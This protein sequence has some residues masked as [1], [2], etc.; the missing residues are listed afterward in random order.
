VTNAGSNDAAASVFG[1]GE[2]FPYHR[3]VLTREIFRRL[4]QG[5]AL[6]L[7]RFRSPGSV[8]LRSDHSR[9]IAA[10]FRLGL[11]AAEVG[12]QGVLG[13]ALPALQLFDPPADFRFNRLSIGR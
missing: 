6:R 2:N 10:S 7:S 3:L 11:Q 4:A 9:Y 1:V 12:V 8:E 5:K 13:N